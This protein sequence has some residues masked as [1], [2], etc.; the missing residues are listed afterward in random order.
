[1][2]A[3]AWQGTQDADQVCLVVDA[4]R[5]WTDDTRELARRLRDSHR[6]VLLILNKVDQLKKDKLLALAGDETGFADVFFV[7]ALTGDG[8]AELKTAL[9]DAMPEG[10]WLF[11]ED[12]VSD[13]PQRLLAAEITR[14]KAF[15]QIHDEIPYGLAVET[16]SW[17]E[18]DDGSIRID[19]TIHLLRD[20]QKPIVVGKGGERIKAIGSAARR[21]LEEILECRVHLFL[22]VKVSEN[23]IEKRG[24]Y[25]SVGLDYDS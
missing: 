14:E 25:S 8:V 24:F 10:H 7:S 22:H 20:S 17:T 23:W 18:K 3:A 1:M 15:L 2:V 13:I 11:P 16:E 19:Q 6:P 9:A 21:E 12:Q 4:T 5:G